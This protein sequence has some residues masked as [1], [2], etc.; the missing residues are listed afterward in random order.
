MEKIRDLNPT[1]MKLLQY[2][3]ECPELTNK[4]LARKLGLN[5]HHYIS[6][7]KSSLEEKQYFVGPYYQTDYGKIFRNR[8]RKATAIILFEK[9]YEFMLS[10]LK[11]ISCFSY[12]YPIEERFFR[13]YMVGIFDSDIEGIRRIFDYLKQEGMIFYYELYLQDSRTQIACPTFLRRTEEA[14]FFP[15]LDNLLED[16]AIPDMSFGEFEGITLSKPETILISYFEKGLSMLTEIKEAEKAKENF[17]TYSE[18]KTAKK[19]LL[20]HQII[21]PVYDVSPL[22][23]ADCSHFFLFL[24]A[25]SLATTRKIVFNFGKN[26]RLFRK[27][28]LWTSYHTGETYGV[29]YCISHPEFTIKLL[30][31]LDAYE[32]IEDKKYFALRKK[33]SLWKGESISMEFYDPSSG[34]LS[35]PYD[36]YLENIKAFVEENAW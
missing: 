25:E 28:F 24:R 20:S 16:T 15:P 2:V 3:G 22:P 32:E 11:H 14:T 13:S 6:T 8:I 31:Q 30:T 34:T 17:F 27:I 26:A 36:S 12:L 19:Q 29:I 23:S 35:Y 1:E 7:L 9:P 18:W 5:N 33:L 4:E 21:Q 10:L